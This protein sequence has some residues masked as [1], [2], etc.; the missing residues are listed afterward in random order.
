MT[1]LDTAGDLLSLVRSHPT[2][3]FFWRNLSTAI[4]A[5]AGTER[6]Q[7]RQAIQASPVEGDRALWLKY[8]A[9]FDIT[10]DWEWAARQAALIDQVQTDAVMEFA[11]LAHMRALTMACTHTEFGTMLA[12][13]GVEKAMVML[14]GRFADITGP[15]V[16]G[17]RTGTRV[18]VYTPQAVSGR[19]APTSMA[20]S[21]VELVCALGHECRLFAGQEMSIPFISGLSGSNEIVVDPGL[22]MASLKVRTAMPVRITIADSSRILERRLPELCLAIDAYRPDLILFVGFFSSLICKLHEKYP[23]IGFSTHAI[24]PLVPVDVWLSADDQASDGATL[25]FPYR[26][27]PKG[28][29]PAD[30]RARAGLPER[31]VLIVTTGHRLDREMSPNWIAHMLTLLDREPDAHWLLVGLL[32][33]QKLTLVPDHP[34]IHLHTHV[35]NLECWLAAADIYANPPRLGGG[36]SVAMAM[37]QGLAVAALAGNDGGDKLGPFA[38]PDDTHYFAALSEWVKNPSARASMGAEMKHRFADRLDISSAAARNGLATALTQA[39]DLAARR[40]KR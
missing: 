2:D 4:K 25:S 21:M 15:G 5:L 32:P 13:A 29:V 22:D 23:V 30:A 1:T 37:E 16:I 6:E 28:P 8:S 19:H 36:A 38:A 27:R 11:W 12:R 40:L 17:N 10:R 18:A 14:A 3:S 31:A 35:A 20:L 26:F 7:V 9:L 33:G 39:G 24:A 34:R